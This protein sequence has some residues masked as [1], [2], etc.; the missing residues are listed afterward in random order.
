[1][2]EDNPWTVKSTQNIY[3]NPWMKVKEHQVI[4]PNGEN[5]IYGV[6]EFKNHAVA[7]LPLFE[8]G[9]TLLVGQYRFTLNR[10]SWEL[11]EGGCSLGESPLS[12]ARR[13]LLE[14]TG[15]EAQEWAE[16]H[17]SDISNSITN[18]K[19]YSFIAKGLKKIS[20]PNPDPSEQLAV[21][22]LPFSEVLKMIDRGEIRDAL[23][24]MTCLMAL[25]SGH[26]QST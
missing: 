26:I 12:A 15:Y 2:S 6:V 18:E 5:G 17:Q 11:P 25:R 14:E 1:M 22:R 4:H 16:V 21:K 7:A 19:S 24:M 20:E 13:E 9:D 8:N 3:E 10:Y 23:T